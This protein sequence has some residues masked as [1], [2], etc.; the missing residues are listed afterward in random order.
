VSFGSHPPAGQA[1][2]LA[3][4]DQLMDMRDYAGPFR[5]VPETAPALARRLTGQALSSIVLGA[6][7]RPNCLPGRRL[8]SAED[9][10]EGM[11]RVQDDAT[12]L[13]A[14]RAGDEAAFAALVGEFHPRMVRFARTFVGDP[15][16]AEEVAQ[17]AWL[18]V[19]R[20]L[21]RF[22]GRSSFQTWVF[23][24]VANCARTRARRERRVLL[25]S[26]LAV[27]DDAEPAVPPERFQDS[28]RWQGHWRSFP[29]D[30]GELPE[31]RLLAQET[32]E[33]ARQAIDGLPA[34]QRA[35]I[36]LRDVDGLSAAET[37][38]VLEISETNQRVLLHRA[39]SRVHRA[40]EAYLSEGQA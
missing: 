23:A 34:N 24:I 6:Y 29:Q 31:G 10:V 5:C 33:V 15:A 39:R 37:C 30:W 20:G 25:F 1:V 14:L 7:R 36:L 16:A 19:L 9:Q 2:R 13:A 22:E 8:F 21:G 35:V 32:L 17:E 3:G 26:D 27:E 4:V 11:C 40:L 12:L 18:G 38:N 28:G